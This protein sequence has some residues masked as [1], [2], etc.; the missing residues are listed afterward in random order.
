MNASTT[1]VARRVLACG[2]RWWR[3]VLHVAVACVVI[4]V[5]AQNAT[6]PSLVRPTGGTSSVPNI[7]PLP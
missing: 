6:H 5:V 4:A 2:L 3:T 1:V 7:R